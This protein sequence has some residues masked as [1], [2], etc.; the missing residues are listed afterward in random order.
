M[1]WNVIWKVKPYQKEKERILKVGTISSLEV[2]KHST[3][4]YFI[5]RKSLFWLMTPKVSNHTLLWGAC[6]RDRALWENCRGMR[7]FNTEARERR[8]G[9]ERK[10]RVRGLGKGDRQ[11]DR[12]RGDR[13]RDRSSGSQDLLLGSSSNYLTTSSPLTLPPKGPYHLPIVPQSGGHC[14]SMWAFGRHSDFQL[15]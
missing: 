4:K 10:I 3:A 12:H 7:I 14:F 6:E 13:D 11:T 15:S 9:K 1:A 5:K 2:G 8:R